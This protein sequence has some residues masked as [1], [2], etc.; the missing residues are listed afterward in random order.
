MH[1]LI[2]QAFFDNHL[3]PYSP[4]VHDRNSIIVRKMLSYLRNKDIH[5]P[6]IKESIV[7]PQV[8]KHA[9]PLEHIVLV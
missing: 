6:R 9:L 8:L 3:I 4:N 7:A 1:N 2:L 5:A